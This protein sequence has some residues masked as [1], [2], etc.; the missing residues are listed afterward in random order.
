MRHIGHWLGG[1][2]A[3]G[4]WLMPGATEMQGMIVVSLTVTFP[5]LLLLSFPPSSCR[6]TS[7]L[8]LPPAFLRWEEGKRRNKRSLLTTTPPKKPKEL[9]LPFWRGKQMILRSEIYPCPLVRTFTYI[10]QRSL[11]VPFDCLP[12]LKSLPCRLSLEAWPGIASL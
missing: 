10:A 8:S 12:F 4:S 2:V 3:K 7:H 5:I 11:Q 1:G 6:H 9:H